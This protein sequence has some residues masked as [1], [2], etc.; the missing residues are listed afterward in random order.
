[1]ALVRIQFVFGS[2]FDIS[3]KSCLPKNRKNVHASY[4]CIPQLLFGYSHPSLPFSLISCVTLLLFLVFLSVTNLKTWI[5]FGWNFIK[6]KKSYRIGSKVRWVHVLNDD[7]LLT[8]LLWLHLRWWWSSLE[9]AFWGCTS[10]PRLNK[11][12]CNEKFT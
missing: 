1:M 9:T 5:N 12:S 10:G 6:K 7:S 2:D 8:G 4:K 3:D 11:S